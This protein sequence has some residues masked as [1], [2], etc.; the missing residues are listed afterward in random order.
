MFNK[1]K[2]VSNPPKRRNNSNTGGVTKRKLVEMAR[3][4]GPKAAKYLTDKAV[5]YAVGKLTRGSKTTTARSVARME[6]SSSKEGPG[7][8][9]GFLG[10][11]P[12]RRVVSPYAVKGVQMI[13]EDGGLV[14]GGTMVAIGHATSPRY[15]ML[16]VLAHAIVRALINKL[17]ILNVEGFATVV[18]LPIGSVF[19]VSLRSLRS[20]AAPLV[21]NTTITV[22]ATTW[23]DIA[24]DLLTNLNVYTDDNADLEYQYFGVVGLAD[25]VT[26]VNL[27]NANLHIDIKSSMKLQNRSAGNSENPDAEAVSNVPVYGKGYEGRGTGTTKSKVGNV[28]AADATLYPN[29]ETGVMFRTDTD[30]Q[31]L[32][33]PD[34]GSAFLSVSKTSKAKIEPGEI[35]SS[36]LTVTRTINMTTFLQLYMVTS[37]INAN[38]ATVHKFGK[39]RFFLLEKMIEPF[40]I[41]V[42]SDIVV[43]YEHN[44]VYQ[45]YLSTHDRSIFQPVTVGI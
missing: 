11:K 6:V 24:E 2:M 28:N 29:T 38:P 42:R 22:G 5:K 32:K 45:M 4:Y 15:M 13:R 23:G 34:D 7:R 40:T 41:G 14:T 39:F 9:G 37:N 18:T 8:S 20:T 27:K 21:F 36:V 1:I 43:A 30:S 25:E 35:K 10:K 26:Y 44:I 16:K 31:L 33:E 12:K 3:T 19:Q 17:S